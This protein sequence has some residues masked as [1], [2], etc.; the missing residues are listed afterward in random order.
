M[1]VTSIIV[2]LLLLSGFSMSQSYTSNN[3]KAVKLY[4]EARTLMGA[5]S[6][7]KAFDKLEVA[8]AKDPNFAEAYLKLATIYKI[9]MQDSLQMNCYMEVVTRYPYNAR[10]SSAWYYLGEHDFKLGSYENALKYLNNYQAITSK[11]GKFS[12]KVK[13]MIENCDFA[14]KYKI[15]DFQ[16]NPRPLSD[17]VN[18]FKQQYFPVLT[19][20][21]KT[22]IY[23]KRE[24][25][26]EIMISEIDSLSN[27]GV[28]Q[29]ISNN[30]NSE[31]NEGTCSISADGRKLVFTSCMGRRGYG[32]CDL[33]QSL[34]V[35]DE[36]SLPV[37]MGKNI[38]STAWDSQP[39]LSADGRMLYFV[40]NRSGGFG[41]RDI[42]LSKLNK[43]EQW[44]KPVNIGPDIN[45]SFD[46]IS[47]FIHP[48]GQ[49][50]YFSTDGRLGFGGFDI[51]FSEKEENRWSRP[52][53]FG[54]PINTHNDEV[55][56]YISSD[57]RKGFYSHEEKLGDTFASTLFEIDIP[58]ELQIENKSSY[59]FGAVINNNTKEPLLATIS[60]IDLEKNKPIELVSTD[61]I[62]G[63]Y[64]IVLTE[65]KDYGL[66]AESPGYLYK[67]KNFNLIKELFEPVEV[68]I[69][70]DPIAIGA[71]II[72]NNIFFEF[73]SYE[74]TTTSTAALDKISTLFD[75][76]LFTKVEITGYTDNVGNEIYNLNLS[77]KRAQA[78]YNYLI[79]DGIS[80]SKLSFLGLGEANFLNDNSTE[81]LRSQNRRIEFKIIE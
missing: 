33:Y 44:G 58:P 42:Y 7:D 19:A 13:L 39:S 27:W 12:S 48:N 43:N 69:A 30:I 3:K 50:L 52:T 79:E 9:R 68:N 49:R 47:P 16:F 21:Q 56:M 4:T 10:F 18:Q 63:G 57:G 5:R 8:I 41:R 53:N 45:S 80:S 20:D 36:W 2:F 78:V 11:R 26:E 31:F 17:L 70:L 67:S 35:G 22:L 32:S 66:F 76:N 28:P 6:F 29:S 40:S 61:S 72:L 77:K 37:N 34:K 64:L 73:N 1:R 65:G 38:N 23:V 81:L 59:V 15:N 25:N 62:T 71:K 60:L 24:E 54:Y 75:N 14:I 74:L 51:Y 46:D 55:S